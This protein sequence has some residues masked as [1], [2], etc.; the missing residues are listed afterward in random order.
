MANVA[1][2]GATTW[3]NALGRLLADKGI[4][5]SI[6]ARTEAKARK[7]RQEQQNRPSETAFPNYLSF[8]NN[9]NEVLHSAELVILAVPA[10][11]LRQSVRQISDRLTAYAILM[12]VAKGLEADSGKRMSE[13]M[14][15]EISSALHERVCV[16]SGPNLSQEISQG[17]PATSVVA[18][19]DIEVA[20]KVQRLLHSPN[21]SVS[22]SDDII[23]VE[24]CGA[25]KNVIALGAGVVDG[26]SLGDNAKAALITLGWAEVVSLGVALGAK[27][28]TFYG[29][30]GLGDLIATCSSR[31]SRNHYVGCELAKGR[32]LA[33][34]TA[35]MP[36]IAEGIDT[37]VAAHSLAGKLG[38]EV[39]LVDLIY[40]V[41][42]ESLPP[43]EISTRFR[44]GL[45]PESAI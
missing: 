40:K 14:M 3:G 38:L 45:K 23:G 7:L 1:V 11:S 6:W 33:E 28:T 36:N 25:L 9:V 37:T 21:F 8:T 17:L 24:L 29:L 35:S 42:F 31:L 4:A 2:I 26:L 27:A 13:V 43:V 18:G 22:V 5:V 15:E 16:L 12:S 20:K 32:S 19:R 10:Q 44:N 30:A 39:P 34:I 41:L